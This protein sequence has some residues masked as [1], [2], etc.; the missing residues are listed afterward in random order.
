L[1]EGGKQTVL[2]NREPRSHFGRYRLARVMRFAHDEQEIVSLARIG[3]AW[4]V[5]RAEVELSA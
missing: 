5:S 2:G 1:I 4:E 3:I